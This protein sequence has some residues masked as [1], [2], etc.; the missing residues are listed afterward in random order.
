MQCRRAAT[1]DRVDGGTGGEQRAGGTAGTGELQLE[2]V[3]MLLAA[4]AT[5]ADVDHHGVAVADRIQ[6]PALRSAL[7]AERPST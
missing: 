4:G 6:S 5:M 2:I 1:V 7:T 3:R